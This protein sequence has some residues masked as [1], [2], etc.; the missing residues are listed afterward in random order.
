[1]YLGRIVETGP[2]ETIYTTPRHPYTAALLSAVPVPDPAEQRTREK[3]VLRGDIPSP[4]NPPSGCR[5]H[6]RCPA[7]MDVCREVD[8]SPSQAA[9]GSVTFCHLYPP[10]NSAASNGRAGLPLSISPN[11]RG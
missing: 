1:M 2:T 5:F 3:I 10:N 4:A 8:P 7:V 11:G 9:D 6:T